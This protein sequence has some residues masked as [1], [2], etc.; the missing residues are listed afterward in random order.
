MLRMMRW[1]LMMSR[2]MRSR[3][4]EMMMLRMIM[5][6]PKTEPTLCASLR[7]Q[8][9]HQYVTRA[10]LYRN[11]RDKCTAQLE[12]PDQAPAFTITVR[13]PQC[14]HTAWGEKTGQAP[15]HY[16]FQANPWALLAYIWY[17]LIPWY[18][19]MLLYTY[20]YYIYIYVYNCIYTFFWVG[21]SRDIQALASNSW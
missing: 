19:H 7:S 20:Y 2:I 11:L 6:R 14:G 3:R 9:A 4:R 5:L 10:T 8:N 16:W 18:I 12:H 17:V 21:L 1:R 13:T 15:S